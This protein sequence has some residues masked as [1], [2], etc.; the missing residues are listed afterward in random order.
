[1]SDDVKVSVVEFGDRPH[2]QM[3][4][5]DPQTGRKRTKT[6]GVRRT[7]LKKD[8]TEAERVAAKHEAELRA[9]RYKPASKMTWEE[10]CERYEDEVLTTLSESDVSSVGIMAGDTRQK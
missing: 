5:K 7:G 2:Y 6:T 10:F 1:M 4:W 9:G 3:Q 8:R